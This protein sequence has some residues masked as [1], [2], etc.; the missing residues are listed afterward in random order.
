MASTRNDSS[1]PLPATPDEIHSSCRWPVLLLAG[2]AIL[3]SVVGL[4]LGLLS[5]IKM[6]VPGMWASCPW[7][8]FGR[9]RPAFFAAI[10]FGFLSQAAL[11][12]VL[13]TLCRLG[14]TVLA[15]R[16]LALLGTLVW[17]LGVAV[18]VLQILG[19]Q[20]TGLAGMEIPRQGASLLMGGYFLVALSAFYTLHRRREGALYI[21]HWFYV[22]AL[23]AL[24]WLF[25]VAYLL[26]V[27]DPV[28]GVMQ[29]LVSSYF[30]NGILHLWIVPLGLGT[31]YYFLPKLTGK[32][33]FSS[34]A[35]AFGFWSLVVV[36]N[37]TGASLLANGPVPRW[38]LGAGVGAKWLM[39]LPAA[40]YAF[41]YFGTVNTGKGNAGGTG[42]GFLKLGSL[43]YLLWAVL[44]VIGSTS[45]WIQTVT[46]TS[47]AQGLDH[48]A[49]FGF[50][51]LILSGATHY[52]VEKLFGK[53]FSSKGWISAQLTLSVL[54][55]LLLGA[56]YILGGL[57]HGANLSNTGLAFNAA[58]KSF[59]PFI[60]VASLGYVLLLAGQLAAAWGL[61]R[62]VVSS[63]A[64]ERSAW[65][66]WC[67]NELEAG[68]KA[69]VRV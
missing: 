58:T 27:V 49:L 69:K 13:W 8:T 9:V 61:F 15:H 50:A 18:G 66:A 14:R 48:L 40:A 33:V 5:S 17:N 67:C 46:F 10:E 54:G 3:W 36:A 60:G 20:S 65:C 41:N 22:A 45:L 7:V 64:D 37:W 6:H 30:S 53:D 31:A 51:G 44:D 11:G 16:G 32:P 47:F 43:F 21:S 24:P 25:S 26:G 34:A 59:V 63:T 19:G 2:A 1:N 56:G 55:V 52:I 23:L 28:R 29:A 38:I 68:K 62:H 42:F 35:A 57:S 39:L 4:A 12:V